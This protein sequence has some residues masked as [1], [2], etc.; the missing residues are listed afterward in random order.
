MAEYWNHVPSWS[1]LSSDHSR[2]RSGSASSKIG[3]RSRRATPNACCSTGCA[4]PRPNA[5]R[6]RPPDS[7]SSVAHS[8]ATSAGLR[9][10]STA[11]LAPSLIFFVTAAAYVS[12][13]TGSGAGPLMRSDSQSESNP[14]DSRP[15]AS[16]PRCSPSRGRRF[17]SPYPMRTFTSSGSFR[18]QVGVRAELAPRDLPHVHLVGTV[19]EM[20]RA[21][22]R[23]HRGERPVVGDAGAAEQ[24]DRAVDHVGRDA[25]PHDLDGRDLHLRL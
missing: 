17:P 24:L 21:R 12:P 4:M 9:P 6:A 23:V 19:D 22:V 7:T 13:R 2:R 5:G 14:C 10:G 18:T 1:T 25:R 20:Q 8:L 11:T 16:A 3:A 15:A